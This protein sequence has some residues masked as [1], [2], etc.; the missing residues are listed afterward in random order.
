MQQETMSGARIGFRR[1][2]VI[3][4]SIGT[5][6]RWSGA[7]LALLDQRKLPFRS[8]TVHCT[9]VVAVAE[10]IRDMVVRGAPAIGI[11]AAYGVVLGVRAR[12]QADGVDGWQASIKQD[13]A[14]LRAARPTAVNLAWA[15]DRMGSCIE[16]IDMDADEDPEPIMLAE[17]QRIHEEDLAGNLR[18]GRLGAA[19]IAGPCAVITHCNAGAL[20]VGG[21]GTALG[22]VRRG[23]S[24]G[25]ISK[26][27]AGETRPWLQGAR[28]T[29]W[30]LMEDDIPV[31]LI[32]DSAC[33]Y[34][35]ASRAR[36]GEGIGWVI[37]GA[38]RVA[39]N[40][41]VANKIGT[42]SLAIAAR[43]HG[44][45]FMVAAPT[46]T[47]DM[48]IPDG[49]AIPIEMRSEDEVLFL[50]GERVAAEGASA[51]NPVFDVT[52]AN[53]VDAIVTEA[54]VV[55]GADKT[56]KIAAIMMGQG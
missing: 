24:E 32:V 36:A 3:K 37:V 11:A 31:E 38:D 12:Y 43:H 18:M 44:V 20:A 9:S 10:A 47:I 30:E 39:A 55:Q 25:R 7:G 22:V 8:E 51:W 48:T 15:L 46:S 17:A 49:G 5:H 35:M 40:G 56:E 23:I 45:G 42:Y 28:L 41:D 19:L 16:T 14:L 26:V 54:G 4:D 21:Y 6:I 1:G 29:A 53:L 52:P 50:G 33:S 34:L 13:L 2:N 27:Y